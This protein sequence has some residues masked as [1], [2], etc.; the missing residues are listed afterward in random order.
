MQLMK[1]GLGGD[2]HGHNLGVRNG[3]RNE[4]CTLPC[5]VDHGV[6]ED[7]PKVVS[8]ASVT[9]VVTR[10]VTAQNRFRMQPDEKRRRDA[11]F[12]Y[13]SVASDNAFVKCFA[14]VAIFYCPIKTQ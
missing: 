8:A 13:V 6:G 10:M 7:W 9:G 1:P 2:S 4:Q 11:G 12:I 14:L 5:S 3:D